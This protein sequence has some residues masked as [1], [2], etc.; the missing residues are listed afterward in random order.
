MHSHRLPSRARVRAQVHALESD[1]SW[2]HCCTFS[3]DTADGSPSL[4]TALRM[5]GHRLY[6]AHS[7]GQVRARANPNRHPH[8]KSSLTPTLPPTGES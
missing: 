1:G 6:C 2:G 4:V 7:T 3:F 8:L 5:R